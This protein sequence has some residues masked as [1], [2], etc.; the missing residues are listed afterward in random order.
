MGFVSLLKI[1]FENC[2]LSILHCWLDVG[3]ADS[4]EG[5]FRDWA[6]IHS[7]RSEKCKSWNT[8]DSNQPPALLNSPMVGL[9]LVTCWLELHCCL[10]DILMSILFAGGLTTDIGEML[11]CEVAKQRIQRH[12]QFVYCCS[13]K[14]CVQLLSSGDWTHLIQLGLDNG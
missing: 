11:S 7:P 14:G 12:W 6:L 5:I 3:L 8:M 9:E 1:V 10:T 4:C 2:L 13:F